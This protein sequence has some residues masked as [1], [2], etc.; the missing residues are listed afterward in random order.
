[1][2]P[3]KLDDQDIAH[4][5]YSEEGC[6][7]LVATENIYVGR[8]IVLLPMKSLTEPDRYSIEAS[9]GAHI[10]C[11][12]SLAGAI[13]HSCNPNA[14]MR[15]FRIVAWECIKAGEEITIDY[16]VTESHIAFPFTCRCCGT[17]IRGNKDE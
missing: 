8:T 16:R 6:R 1:M 13:N 7:R 9:P 12:D 15:H 17:L 4:I 5:E 3:Q 2:D 11:T 14:R 10:D